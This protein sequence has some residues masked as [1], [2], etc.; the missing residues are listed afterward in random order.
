MAGA[1]NG[2]W[3][4]PEEESLVT[5][6]ISSLLFSMPGRI[7]VG[8]DPSRSCFVAVREYCGEP[9]TA[10]AAFMPPGYM[11]T[12]SAAYTELNGAPRLPLFAYTA[13]GWRNGRFCAAGYRIDRQKRHT[14]P[15][16]L[17]PA[18]D[19]RA[20][21]MLKRYP[22]NRLVA[23]LMNNCVLKYRCPN[24]CNLALGRWECP[25]PVSP[26]CNAACVGCI[27]KQSGDSCV[28]STQHRLDFVPTVGE[29]VEYVVPH[30][31]SAANPI[32]SFGQG[33][34]GEPLLQARLVEEAIGEIR[35][36]TG[37]GVINI[38]TN[39]SMP[40]EVERLCRAG[41]NSMRVSLN[42]AQ[43]RFYSAYYRPRGYRFADAVESIKI[44]KKYGVWVSLN[45]LVFPGFT[46]TA[47]EMTALE[48]LLRT[49]GVDMIQ[50]RNL[51][52]DPLW[53]AEVIGPSSRNSKPIGMIQWVCH[54]RDR[55][56]TVRLGYFNPSR[57]GR[58]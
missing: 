16:S 46:D 23:H 29:I 17:L 15:D 51:N 35:R 48:R 31:Q 53:Y 14:I 49:T 50:T 24:A 4:V 1:S 36:R 28:P 30:L 52:I 13:V 25:V 40:R 57:I 2:S 20:R 43:E 27:S 47:S 54:L 11:Q 42:S 3:S 58:S 37:R 44:A 22:R 32:A 8:Y 55:F 33:C 34:E 38:N 7:P 10:A 12:L 5:L 56:P 39:A 9:V 6:P 45:Y 18:I 26:A 21:A 19:S 41:L